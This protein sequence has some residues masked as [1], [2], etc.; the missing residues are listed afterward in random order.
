LHWVKLRKPCY[1]Q[2]FP[3]FPPA[4]ADIA[5]CDRGTRSK[6]DIRRMKGY[7]TEGSAGLPGPATGMTALGPQADLAALPPKVDTAQL[8]VLAMLALDSARA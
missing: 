5:S 6:N 1:E 7:G 2:C 8:V 3:L 4:I